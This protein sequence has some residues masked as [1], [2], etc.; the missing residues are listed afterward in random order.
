MK[1]TELVEE[2]SDYLITYLKAGRVGI[3]SFIKKAELNVSQLDELLMIHFLLKPEVKQFVRGLPILLR[4]FKTS[5]TEENITFQGEVRGSINW[6]KT[7]TERIKINHRDR[8]IFL[9]NESVKNYN[10]VENIVLKELICT[11]YTVLYQKIDTSNLEK[12]SY[13]KE[14]RE[15]KFIVSEVY[16]KNVYLLKVDE[17]KVTTRMIQKAMTHRN[18]LYRKAAKLLLDY[19][20]IMKARYDREVLQ[21]LLME[22]FIFPEKEEVLFELYWTI[23]IIKASAKNAQLHLINGKNNLVAS[24]ETDEYVYQIYHDSAGSPNIT[25]NISTEEISAVEHPFIEKKIAAMG[26]ALQLAKQSL[27]RG[28]DST[29]FWRGRPDIIVEKYSKLTGQLHKVII[30]EVKDTKKADYAITG[31]RELVEYMELIK[32]RDG[33]YLKDRNTGIVEGMLFLGDIVVKDTMVDHIKIFTLSNS[34][35]QKLNISV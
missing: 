1:R 35:G 27:G 21:S 32:G 14:W 31:L 24:W 33:Q 9:C 18:S 2:V 15:L 12:H 26:T 19:R 25:F 34:N 10:I 11:I 22:T 28:F 3:N 7:I 20:E 4:R 16:R 17:G 6:E 5:T 8:T 23:Q 30:G 29:T 13:F